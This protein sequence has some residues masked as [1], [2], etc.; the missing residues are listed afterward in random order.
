VKLSKSQ[1]KRKRKWSRD[2]KRVEVSR[3]I[4]EPLGIKPILCRLSHLFSALILTFSVGD[5]EASINPVE[6]Q[7]KPVQHE[8]KRKLID[9]ESVKGA[10][11]TDLP[12][13]MWYSFHC[14]WQLCA[15]FSRRPQG[16]TYRPR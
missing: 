6:S 13:G 14:I 5:E 10:V 16:E 2:E 4:N 3:E 12:L 7:I 8:N 1:K 9:E 15:N 11:E